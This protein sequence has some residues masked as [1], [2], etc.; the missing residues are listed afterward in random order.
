MKT[1]FKS[2]VAACAVFAALSPIGQASAATA[3]ETFK[4]HEAVIATK[5]C[6]AVGGYVFGVGRAISKNGGAA[7]GFGKAR[8]LAFGKIT[9]MARER[10]RWPDD[11]PDSERRKAW[12]L[13]MADK[14][15]SLSLEG[16]ETI[17]EKNEDN[18]RFMAVIAIREENLLRAIP[19][20]ETL[21]RY[22]TLARMQGADDDGKKDEPPQIIEYEPRGYWEESGVKANET[23]SE[24]QF[25]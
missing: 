8:L 20:H 12:R 1:H 15:F 7:V 19:Q 5:R 21:G 13:L 22:L 2:A 18:G 23:M 6:V 3:A 9:D 24:S 11:C 10:A 4:A 14:A 16:C 25:L 17:I